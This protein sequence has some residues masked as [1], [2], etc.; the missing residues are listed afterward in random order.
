MHFG[1]A[2]TC[3]GIALD[4]REQG[5]EKYIGWLSCAILKSPGRCRR[6]KNHMSG[7]E[8]KNNES[9]NQ[10]LLKRWLS[11]P[12]KTNMEPKKLVLSR[13]FSFSRGV[14]SASCR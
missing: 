5:W 4:Q 12:P 14:F 13:Y 11:I 8:G 2:L 9:E 1:N 3:L 6:G 10:R 7:A